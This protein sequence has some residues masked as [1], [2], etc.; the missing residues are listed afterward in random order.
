[1]EGESADLAR[2][3]IPSIR[4]QRMLITFTKSQPRKVTHSDGQRLPS[5]MVSPPHW[6]PQ[7]SRSPSHHIRQPMGPKHYAP[8]QTN[9]VL[10]APP[11][12]TQIPPPNTGVQ[13]LFVTTP[14]SPPLPFVAPVSVPPPGSTG[15]PAAAPRHPPI[16]PRLPLPGT[17]VFLPPPGSSGSSCPQPPSRGVAEMT[18]NS[19]EKPNNQTIAPLPKEELNGK[20]ERQDCNETAD[21]E[22]QQSVQNTLAGK[23]GSEV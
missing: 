15:W 5:S 20:T 18:I 19:T 1:M 22:K 14:V 21:G 3:A 7:P 4:K 6:G 13:P 10:P 17:G 23:S 11:I 16:P 12:R 8:I 9:G 2:H